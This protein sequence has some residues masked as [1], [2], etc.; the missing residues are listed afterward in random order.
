ME[1]I[2]PVTA[3]AGLD[4]S[5]KALSDIQRHIQNPEPV[6]GAKCKNFATREK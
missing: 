6:G 1:N 5:G 4:L 3:F 2:A